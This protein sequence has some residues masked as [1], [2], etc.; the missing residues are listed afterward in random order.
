MAVSTGA[1]GVWRVSPTPQ[2]RTER[3]QASETL[4]LSG[5]DSAQLLTLVGALQQQG[6]A[7]GSL[8]WRLSREAERQAHQEATKQALTVLRGRAEEAAGLL[9]LRF[10]QFKDVRL[11]TA[12][13]RQPMFRAMPAMAMAA[14]PA[15]SPPAVASEDVAVTAT[16]EA[17]VILQPR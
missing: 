17:D 14:A 2:D 4:N 1:Y 8:G 5:H 13:P 9:D 7:V 12:G 11:D 10:E 3:W 15:A 16:A 6:L